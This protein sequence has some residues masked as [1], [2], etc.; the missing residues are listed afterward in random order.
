MIS[1]A[2]INLTRTL[3]ENTL[4]NLYFIQSERNTFTAIKRCC[5]IFN[6]LRI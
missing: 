4:S 1:K 3:K 2:K 5:K 6:I